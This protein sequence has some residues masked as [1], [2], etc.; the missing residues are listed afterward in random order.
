MKRISRMTWA[1]FD[2]FYARFAK[3][4]LV[5]CLLAATGGVIIGTTA[6]L[7]SG[8]AKEASNKVVTCLES[9]SAENSRVAAATRQASENKDLAVTAFN[10]TLNDEGQAFLALV[11]AIINP[12]TT[13]ELY[14]P[15]LLKLTRTLAARSDANA[16][17]IHSQRKLNRVRDKNPIPPP[18]AEF[19]HLSS[20]E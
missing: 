2:R 8:K 16:L 18:P 9:W 6:Q 13:Q 1:A 19:C 15:L 11:Q 4:L 20:K 12:A 17:V 3:L 5:F 14:Q 7:Q 10:A